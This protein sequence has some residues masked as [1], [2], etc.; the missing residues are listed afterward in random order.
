[1]TTRI[2]IVDDEYALADVLADLLAERGHEAV[3]AING[4]IGLARLAESRFDLVLLDVMM[5]VMDGPALLRAMRGDPR[6]AEIPVVM[7]TAIPASFPATEPPAYQE[8]LR[9]PFSTE[10]LFA[11]VARALD[12]RP[13][14]EPGRK[15]A[16][17]PPTRRAHPRRKP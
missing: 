11:T 8:M 12:G 7:M 1:M 13:A 4:R 15:P 5:P 17:L 10:A 16:P 2:L 3:V 6:H 9:K 14:R